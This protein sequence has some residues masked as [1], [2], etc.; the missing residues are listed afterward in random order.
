MVPLVSHSTEQPRAVLSA[1]P[2]EHSLG[3]L[4]AGQEAAYKPGKQP[5]SAAGQDLPTRSKSRVE[6]TE[7]VVEAVAVAVVDG[8][9]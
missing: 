8:P 6:G 9:G 7:A 2:V 1:M 5:C 3:P 4:V